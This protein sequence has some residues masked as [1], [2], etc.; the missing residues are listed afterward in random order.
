MN[1]HEPW[2]IVDDG[3]FS[4]LTP[5]TII[6]S[7]GEAVAAVVGAGDWDSLDEVNRETWRI[8]ALI[9]AAPEMRAELDRLH[10]WAA[11]NDA[12]LSGEARDALRAIIAGSA[13]LTSSDGG[14]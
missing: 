6:N 3:H 9:A 11:G 1:N 14:I 10:R 4:E 12:T 8:A 13:H 7:R 5:L 2:S